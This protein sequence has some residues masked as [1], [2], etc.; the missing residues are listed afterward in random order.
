[1]LKYTE[2]SVMAVASFI[3]GAQCPT[4]SNRGIPLVPLMDI[5]HPLLMITQLC[6]IGHIA[7]A[8]PAQ[9]IRALFMCFL[10]NYQL[11][12]IR[13]ATGHVPISSN[14]QFH[15]L[16]LNSARHRAQDGFIW[17]QLTPAVRQLCPFQGWVPHPLKKKNLALLIAKYFPKE[18][19]GIQSNL[20]ISFT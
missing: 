7:G 1:M 17:H 9:T 6:L 5:G 3:I 8:Y 2:K 13:L 20:Q 11:T 18:T 19:S 4:C 15:N 12:P 10:G 16:S 14:H